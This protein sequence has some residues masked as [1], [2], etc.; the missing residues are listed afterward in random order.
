MP[1]TP[2]TDW[3]V[4]DEVDHD[5]LNNLEQAV[6]DA[7]TEVAPGVASGAAQRTATVELAPL[8]AN[9][10]AP[11]GKKTV[12][13]MDTTGTGAITRIWHAISATDAK[14]A[15]T[16]LRIYADD[17]DT[18]TVDTSLQAF[19]CYRHD[20]EPYA[21]TVTG[22]SARY[23][24]QAGGWRNTWVP[25]HHW[26]RVEVE[27]TADEDIQTFYG[28][29]DYTLTDNVTGAYRFVENTAT[30]DPY[31]DA[32]VTVDGAGQ[33]ESVSAIVSATGENVWS[34]LEGNPVVETDTS[35]ITAPGGEDFFNGAWYNMPHAAHPAGQVL[36][37]SDASTSNKVM[38][39]YFHNHA[40]TFNDGATFTLPLGQ[41][42]QGLPMSDP[43]TATV[44]I[45]AWLTEP[46][47]P[48]HPTEG[49]QVTLPAFTHNAEL[50]T[51]TVSGNSVTFPAEC[52]DDNR[53]AAGT[54]TTDNYR[55]TAT[56]TIGE[57]KDGG[58]AGIVFLSDAE[59]PY[60]GSGCH[61]QIIR[62]NS[63][64][65][66]LV[67]H[68]DWDQ[69]ATAVIDSGETAGKS[70]DVSATV[71]DG[72]VTVAWRPTGTGDYQTVGSW[73]ASKHGGTVGAMSWDT[74]AT[75]DNLTMTK[76]TT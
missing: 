21:G 63:D 39:R 71:I 19:M 54:T 68:D 70:Y 28:I 34:W 61:L 23:D 50:P 29:V 12:V 66:A 4:D 37:P 52:G 47:A 38:Y 56:V 42:G 45:G 31:E 43:I 69:T 13:L 32:T 55:L 17:A 58:T 67:A 60:Y 64:Q 75:V 18:P 7:T 40:P 33:V 48:N 76:I 59:D 2:K 73:Q 74:A 1:Y 3:K 15:N 72:V 11:A 44:T 10:T 30:H 8:L 46:P 14:Y 27:N 5:H 53:A 57:Q 51:V 9:S 22:K 25:F 35:R 36:T 20:T 49:P 6:A 24:G 62:H 26:A 65:T 41:H 16:R